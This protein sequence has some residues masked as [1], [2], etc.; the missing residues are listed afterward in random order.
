MGRRRGRDID[1]RVR[2][3]P[4]AGLEIGEDDG[5]LRH[6][7]AQSVQETGRQRVPIHRS[8][9]RP[10]AKSVHR[11]RDAE[12]RDRGCDDPGPCLD[13]ALAQQSD[14]DR[15]HG[16]DCRDPGRERR[17]A[18]VQPGPEVAGKR[19]LQG[20]ARAERRRKH[21]QAHHSGEDG[22]ST[23]ERKRNRDE[24]RQAPRL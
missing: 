19:E 11:N 16:S 17:T 10:L 8:R 3:D 20:N 22:R 1:G 4:V 21:E 12:E 24:A 9:R 6:L 23:G 2:T 18:L 7:R 14:E 5:A 15:G 13:P